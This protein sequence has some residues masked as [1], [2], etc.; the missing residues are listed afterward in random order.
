PRPPAPPPR[1]AGAAPAAATMDQR[2]V[3]AMLAG[4]DAPPGGIVPPSDDVL[5]LTEQMAAPAETEPPSFQTIDGQSD[6]FFS[7]APAQPESPP[8]AAEEPRRQP[9]PAPSTPVRTVMSPT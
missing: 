5:D 2:D 7:D 4:L 8:H 1:P 6:V 3:D 9:A